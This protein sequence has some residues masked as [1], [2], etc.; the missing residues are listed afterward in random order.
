MSC[1]DATMNKQKKRVKLI[2]RISLFTKVIVSNSLHMLTRISSSNSISFM[3][4]NSSW[5]VGLPMTSSL[6]EIR[7]YTKFTNFPLPNEGNVGANDGT[8]I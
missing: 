5:V 6:N 2:S 4:M 3:L 1:L 8:S 7:A